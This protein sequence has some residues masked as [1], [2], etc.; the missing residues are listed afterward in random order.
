MIRHSQTVF[1]IE[2]LQ[3][4]WLPHEG[5]RVLHGVVSLLSSL[6]GMLLLLILIGAALP[7]I[8]PP[9]ANLTFGNLE[10]SAAWLAL[11]FLAGILSWPAFVI[12]GIT[13]NT[14]LNQ[15]EVY[16]TIVWRPIG[17]GIGLLV[18]VI[19]IVLGS[20]TGQAI[21]AASVGLPIAYIFGLSLGATGRSVSVTTISNQ[22]TWNAVRHAV[23]MTAIA[24]IVPVA[25][26]LLGSLVVREGLVGGIGL[27]LVGLGSAVGLGMAK[28]GHSVVKHVLLRLLLVIDTQLPWEL[29]EFLD[30]CAE[31]GLLRRV[32]GGYIFIHGL[33]LERVAMMSAADINQLLDASK[34][35]N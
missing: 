34:R 16:E 18:W 22:G 25:V 30:Q 7:V 11:G 17:V 26:G 9:L 24:A 1:L 5:W 27:A 3:P 12:S 19:L 20:L 29:A 23:R 8:A 14:L 13:G 10:G 2:Q 28:G 6:I 21:L 35:R 31:R 15:I 33:L 32:G 4:S